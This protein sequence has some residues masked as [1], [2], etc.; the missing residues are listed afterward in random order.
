MND[1]VKFSIP[2]IEAARRQLDTA[3][4][5]WFMEK[6][7]VSVHTLAYAAYQI[8][9][10][11]NAHRRTAHEGLFETAMIKD[12]HRADWNKLVRKP[13]NFFKHADNDPD[14]T[15]E[16]TPVSNLMFL[17]YGVHGL[18]FLLQ[19]SGGVSS[20]QERIFS[21]WLVIHRPDFV[22]AGYRERL[23]GAI[24]AKEIERL[25][26]LSKPEFFQDLVKQAVAFHRSEP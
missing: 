2:K 18:G 24:P 11:I 5:L 16:F 22:T 3:I 20:P 10:D 12:E 25:R 4:E 23:Q 1:D 19:E 17:T 7:E 13:A 15:V 9:H 6:D 8:I 26:A 14:G 21:L